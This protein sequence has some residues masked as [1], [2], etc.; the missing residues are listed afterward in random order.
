[1]KI[2]QKTWQE[3]TKDLAADGLRPIE[4]TKIIE[5]EFGGDMYNKVQKYMKAHCQ[6]TE[7]T[8]EKHIALQNLEPKDH[9]I[10]HLQTSLKMML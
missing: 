8:K 5:S 6:K 1:M 2:I 10:V 3:R 9:N 4:V 7:T